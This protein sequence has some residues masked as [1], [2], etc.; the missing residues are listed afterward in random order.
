VRFSSVGIDDVLAFYGIA[1]AVSRESPP[2][3]LETWYH[4]AVPTNV[5]PEFKKAREAF[6]RA[7]DPSERL[8]CLKEMLRTLPKH[9]GTDHLQADLKRRIKE[10]SAELAAPRTGGSRTAPSQVVRREGAAQ[11]A[12]VGPPNSGKSSLHARLTGS[13]AEVAPYPNTT[14][15]PSPG[16]MPYEDI[17]FQLVDLPPISAEFMEPWMPNA[18]QPADAVLLVVDLATPGCVEN[19]ASIL[20]RLEGKRI[21]LTPEWNG[22][23]DPELLSR[24]CAPA[25]PARPT[26]TALPDGDLLEETFRIRLPTLL[27]SNKSDIVADPSEIDALE[28]LLDV[29]F[30]CLAVSANTGAGLSAI[31]SLLFGGLGVIRVYTKIPGHPPDM[32]RPYTVFRGDTVHDAAQL[33]HRELAGSLKFARVWGGGKFD[34]QQVG[35]DY[36]LQDGD[37]IELHG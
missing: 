10:L 17:H 22:R 23:L 18:L 4:R 15:A 2:F 13:H 37:V 3:R 31:G 26:S 28:D 16:M 6:Q 20:E 12:L 29:R 27:L 30:P 14:H 1:G 11:V 7:R 36:E 19:V 35:R 32:S 8:D 25:N 9:K 24:D 34:G 21:T 33:V 5:T